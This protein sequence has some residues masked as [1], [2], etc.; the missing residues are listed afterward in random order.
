MVLPQYVYGTTVG[1]GGAPDATIINSNAAWISR[2]DATFFNNNT[3]TST[4]LITEGAND[5]L[6][7]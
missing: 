1:N 7:K 3:P 4:V 5:V 6:G 2:A